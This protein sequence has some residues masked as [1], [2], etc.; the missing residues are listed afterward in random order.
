MSAKRVN[1][2]TT[3]L[4]ADDHSVVRRGLRLL[5]A[6]DP[7]IRIIG[8]VADGL[9]AL[10]IADKLRPE[11]IVMDI[12]MPGV[13]GLDVTRKLRRDAPDVK[14]VIFTIHFSEEVAR[15]CLR[16]GARA[17]V[18]KSDAE[19]ELLEALRAVRD[20]QPF[21][22]PRITEMFNACGGSRQY[23]PDAPRALAG[24]IPLERL[25]M[26]ELKVL[27][28]LCEGMTSNQVAS[29]LGLATRT[30]ESQRGHIMKKLQITAFSDLVRYA[31]RH[32][33]VLG[34]LR[35]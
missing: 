11:I 3:V 24:E 25:T 20:N 19:S 21:F 2:P 15:E 26:T 16:A 9:D 35:R 18:L 30:V 28:L 7:T 23:N 31:I 4:L 10:R 5:L 8:E 29:R 34:K 13:N 12:S 22:T 6:T 33:I 27:A 14:V 17:Y 32:G 1:K